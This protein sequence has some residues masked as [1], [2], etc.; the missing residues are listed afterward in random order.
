MGRDLAE[1]TRHLEQLCT[2]AAHETDRDKQ[3]E[4]T[5]EIYR[6]LEEKQ[7]LKGGPSYP[8]SALRNLPTTPGADSKPE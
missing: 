7:K 3:D 6:V 8:G 1:L 5:Q 4:L 2:Q